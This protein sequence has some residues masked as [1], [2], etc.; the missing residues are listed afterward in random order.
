MSD[1]AAEIAAAAAEEQLHF[2]RSISKDPS[3]SWW[4]NSAV[5]QFRRSFSASAKEFTSTLASKMDLVPHH[6]HLSFFFVVKLCT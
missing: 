6:L 4:K 3:S 5:G 2:R 1:G